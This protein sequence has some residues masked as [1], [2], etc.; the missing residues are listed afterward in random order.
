MDEREKALFFFRKLVFCVYMEVGALRPEVH[1]ELAARAAL[2]SSFFRGER[3]KQA[4]QLYHQ[5]ETEE[6][7]A[8]IVRPF[9]E[10]TGLTLSDVFR[11]FAEGNWKNK[12]SG[13]NAGGPKWTRIAA[14]T[15]DLMRAIDAEDWEEAT[16]LSYE[17][18]SL[19]TNFGPLINEF[20]KTERS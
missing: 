2:T 14:I 18:K 3:K 1:P 15:L 10:R 7:T 5:I 11:V 8:R 9:K 17:I 19:K 4:A 20:D 13:F 12:Y 6:E 16:Y